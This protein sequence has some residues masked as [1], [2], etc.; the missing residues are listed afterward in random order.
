MQYSKSLDPKERLLTEFNIA[1]EFLAHKNDTKFDLD[2]RLNGVKAKAGSTGLQ[3]AGY[4]RLEQFYRGDQWDHDEPAGASQ[5]TDNYCSVIVD[6]LSSLLFDDAPEINCPTDDPTDELLELKAEMK[7][8]LLWRVWN[9]NDFE[10]EYDEWAKQASLYG[11]GFLKGTWAEKVDKNGKTISPN[12]KGTWRFKFAHV[13]NPATIRLIYS[14]SGYRNLLGFIQSDRIPHSTATALYGSLAKSKGITIEASINPDP[15]VTPLAGDSQIPMVNI[16]EYW[17]DQ[18]MA[19]FVNDKLLDF[20]VHDWGFVPLQPVKNNYVPN[21]AYGKSDIEDILDPQLSHNRV[22]NDLANLLKW[23]SSV[24]LW[25]KNLEGMQAL[26]AGL[27]RIY[28]LPDDGELHAFEKTGDPYI[29]NTFV[30]QRRSAIIEISGVSEAMMSSSQLSAA[31][32]K[33]LA[34]AFQGTIRKLNPRAK[35]FRVCLKHL[36]ENILKLYEKYFPETQK[37]IEGDYRN[38]VFLPTTLLRNIIDTINKFQIGI[39]SQDTAMREAGVAQPN[40]EKKTMRKDLQDPVL[41]PQVARQPA[42]LPRLSEGQNV[43]GEAPMATPGNAPAA[44]Q[45]GAVAATNNSASGGAPTPK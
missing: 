14:D 42:L 1:K 32:G 37:I 20:Y 35:R 4:T 9:D 41:G 31:S 40:L 24:N 22:N 18:I 28:S 8:R 36:N 21:Y 33:A 44:G 16:D 25:G 43:P 7:E 12:E 6:N 45:A 5:K 23:I 17:T 10:V 11:D 15:A 26:V 39:I 27:S 38:E 2:M 30:A 19:V 3:F 13:E 34:L 29:T